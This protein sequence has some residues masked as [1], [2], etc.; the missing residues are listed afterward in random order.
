MFFINVNIKN[1]LWRLN[2]IIYKNVVDYALV[3]CLYK[4]K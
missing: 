3:T 2:N 1:N 4:L